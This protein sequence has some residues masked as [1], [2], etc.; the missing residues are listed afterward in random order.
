[1]FFVL[2]ELSRARQIRNAARAVSFNTILL[3][4][5]DTAFSYQEEKKVD[6]T[7]IRAVRSG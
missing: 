7:K 5:G 1:M 2:L 3:K 6:R 4:V